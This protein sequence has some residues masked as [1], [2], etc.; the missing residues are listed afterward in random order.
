VSITDFILFERGVKAVIQSAQIK[1][2]TSPGGIEM[3]HVLPIIFIF[4]ISCSGNLHPDL[5]QKP[6]IA[7]I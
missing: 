3:K 4:V 1:T 7:P 6:C 5:H 2:I